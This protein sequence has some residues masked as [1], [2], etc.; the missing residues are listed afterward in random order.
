MGKMPVTQ[1]FSALSVDDDILNVQLIR[2]MLQDLPITIAHAASGEEAISL[3]T[4]AVPDLIF[5]DISLP[6]MYGWQILDRFKNDARLK[7]SSVI[8]LTS[9]T[10]PVH[11]L[12]GNMMPI[13][14][15]LTK[16]INQE[17]MVRLVKQ[18]LNI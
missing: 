15:Y 6:D 16:P 7:D 17:A 18:C 14:A 1:K 9:H 3:L 8:V 2:F 13:V 11:R 5:L 10:E 12:I 4:Q